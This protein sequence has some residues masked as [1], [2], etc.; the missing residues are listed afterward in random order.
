[1]FKNILESLNAKRKEKE[2]Q[3][4]STIH[5]T[6]ISPTNESQANPFLSVIKHAMLFEANQQKKPEETFDSQ[7]PQRPE[8]IPSFRPNEQETDDAIEQNDKNVISSHDFSSKISSDDRPR[9]SSKGSLGVLNYEN[10]SQNRPKSNDNY[11][12]NKPAKKNKEGPKTNDPSKQNVEDKN[13]KNS[14]EPYK[15]NAGTKQASSKEDSSAQML[16]TQPQTMKKR[17]T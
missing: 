1:M 15:L 16:G 10:P 9:E 13:T 14:D 6:D 11:T 8:Q 12:K 2:S 7:I 4:R 5:C 3:R 17:S